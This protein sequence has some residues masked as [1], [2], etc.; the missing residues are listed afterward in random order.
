MRDGRPDDPEVGRDHG[1]PVLPE[2]RPVR[3]P[4]PRREAG[5]DRRPL[6]H[7]LPRVRGRARRPLLR[8]RLQHLHPLRP[9]RPDVPGGARDLRPGLQAPGPEDADRSGVRPEPRGGGVRVLRRLRLR[10][11][12]GHARR[13]GLQ[14]GRQAGRVRG[15][16]LPVLRAR[17]PGRA[18]PQGRTPL[19]G[20]PASRRR[21]QRRPALRSRE[22]LPS[23]GDAP[24]RAGEEAAP[25]AWPLGPGS[26]LGG[27]AR[28]R[29]LRASRAS[30]PRTS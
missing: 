9:L 19:E 11:P 10:L 22:V 1:L 7:H 6:P 30:R 5:R 25:E 23:R 8:P 15:L 20:S 29:L 17:V 14:V 4:G 13:Q 2:R 16:D 24:P 3:A 12:D 27:G 28:R 21:D 18:S 26:E